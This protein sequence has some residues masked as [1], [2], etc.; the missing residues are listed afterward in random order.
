MLAQ[1]WFALR[2]QNYIVN[3][4][5]KISFLPVFGGLN[6]SDSWDKLTP[7]IWAVMWL[8]CTIIEA[9]T[10]WNTADSNANCAT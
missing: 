10:I 2:D 8:I 3:S 6:N 1:E 9:L 7:T 4:I 5:L